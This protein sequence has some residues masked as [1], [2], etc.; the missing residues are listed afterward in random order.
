MSEVRLNLIDSQRILQGT[1]HGS[2]VDA[3]VAALSA[4][5]ETIAEPDAALAR[6]IKPT[7][8]AANQTRSFRSFRS[9][10][11]VDTQP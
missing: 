5:P 10:S 11:E 3:C 2:V 1:I 9:T 4:E 7:G 6:Y 8:D